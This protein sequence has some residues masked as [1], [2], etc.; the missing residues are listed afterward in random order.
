MLGKVV[1]PR[2]GVLPFGYVTDDLGEPDVGAG[3]V[4]D[5]LHD[6][7]RPK[8]GFI[9]SDPPAFLLVPACAQRG[10]EGTPGLVGFQVLGRIKPRKV[11]ADNLLGRVPLDVLC[12]GIP[13]AN[14]TIRIEHEDRM[15]GQALDQQ[16]E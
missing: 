1:D 16:P 4:A 2:L 7:T 5:R 9:F 13:V 6:D 12:A 10:F 8:P 11:L 14:M 15:V 3:V